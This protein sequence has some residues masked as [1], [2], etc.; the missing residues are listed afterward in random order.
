VC[1]LD[2][3][4]PYP[5][6][7]GNFWGTYQFESHANGNPGPK[8]AYITFYTT[9][10]NPDHPTNY[11]FFEYETPDGY[12]NSI[13]GTWKIVL[14]ETYHVLE[15]W[16]ADEDDPFLHASYRLSDDYTYLYEL[17]EEGE[18]QSTYVKVFCD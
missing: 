17:D 15:F 12:H 2:N 11:L 16:D 4:A 14:H 9:E 6:F 3:E 10:E 18:T 1:F 8:Y 13:E 7:D 5:Q